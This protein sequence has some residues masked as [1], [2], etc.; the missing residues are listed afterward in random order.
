MQN[1]GEI[2]KGEA[3]QKES[4]PIRFNTDVIKCGPIRSS[5][6][7]FLDTKSYFSLYCFSKYIPNKID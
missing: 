4:K 1:N 2:S 5:L 6:L 7:Q 3:N